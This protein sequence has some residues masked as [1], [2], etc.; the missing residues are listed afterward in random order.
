MRSTAYYVRHN[1]RIR[2]QRQAARVAP[3]TL[4]SGHKKDVVLTNRALTDLP[5]A[6]L[7]RHPSRPLDRSE[8]RVLDIGTGPGTALFGVLEFFG[9]RAHR[10]ALAL[11]AVDQVEENLRE[12]ADAL[13]SQV[14]QERSERLK[15]DQG[16]EAAAAAV[17]E[18]TATMHE[19]S[20]NIQ[21]V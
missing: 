12:A 13:K 11:L 7:E 14:E 16:A 8:L 18:T 20:A 3:G 2:K 21:S 19:M 4:V 15:R 1:E 9:R 5:L 6:E 10:P 17:E